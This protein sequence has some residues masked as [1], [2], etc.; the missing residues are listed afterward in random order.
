MNL[1]IEFQEP[2]AEE[3]APT[4]SVFIASRI[5]ECRMDPRSLMDLAHRVSTSLIKPFLE[6]YTS[7]KP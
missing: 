4:V 1:Q 6:P 5:G 3:S 7:I 2:M